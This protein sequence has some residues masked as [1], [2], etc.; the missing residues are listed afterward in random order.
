MPVRRRITKR[1]MEYPP[2][3]EALLRGE[4]PEETEENREALILAYFINRF[5]QLD[6]E[7]ARKAGEVLARWRAKRPG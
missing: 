7:I 1:R 6:P 3:I 4:E 5:P 2:A